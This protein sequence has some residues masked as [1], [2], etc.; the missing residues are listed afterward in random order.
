MNK[1][2]FPNKIYAKNKK[3]KHFTHT[4]TFKYFKKRKLSAVLINQQ[5]KQK[6]FQM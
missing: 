4:L 5:T 3:K 1:K 2:Y 6:T